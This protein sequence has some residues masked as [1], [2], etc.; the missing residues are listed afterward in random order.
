LG[1]ILNKGLCIVVLFS[2]LVVP[3]TALQSE[4]WVN[5][6][7]DPDSWYGFYINASEDATIIINLNVT[8]GGDAHLFIIEEDRFESY[9]VNG[10]DLT[11]YE[12][13]GFTENLTLNFLVPYSGVWYFLFWN[14]GQDRA[15]HIQ[16][17]VIPSPDGFDGDN[18]RY[19]LS[20]AINFVFVG[21]VAFSIC[22]CLFLIIKRPKPS[23][24]STDE[25]Q[26]NNS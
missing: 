25:I 1:G 2:L 7:I 13:Y 16:G 21:T 11:F 20:V 24:V 9:R 8:S 5:F 14:L 18:S 4:N 10:S 23:I 3:A 15:I 17:V 26:A 12:S 6:R 19:I 22:V